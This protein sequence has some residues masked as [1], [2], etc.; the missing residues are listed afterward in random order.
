MQTAPKAPSAPPSPA[1]RVPFV[2]KPFR[3]P[4]ADSVMTGTNTA[5][6][7]YAIPTQS[8]ALSGLPNCTC[9]LCKMGPYMPHEITAPST[10]TVQTIEES[11]IQRLI[12]LVYRFPKQYSA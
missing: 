3:L 1:E 10:N 6:K 7:K 2:L 4:C 9:P 12:D 11:P 5:I 8:K